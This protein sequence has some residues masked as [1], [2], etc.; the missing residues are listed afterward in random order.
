M[1]RRDNK[2]S[3]KLREEFQS[4]NY[5]FSIIKQ[6]GQG[7]IQN[8]LNVKI[9]T[10]EKQMQSDQLA[11]NYNNYSNP[12]DRQAQEL[13]SHRSDHLGNAIAGAALNSSTLHPLDESTMY[14]TGDNNG[15]EGPRIR[16]Q[17]RNSIAEEVSLEGRQ[18]RLGY[19]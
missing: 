1:I 5:K 14:Y 3:K 19:I 9:P 15:G 13:T 6:R 11:N 2:K 17:S 7:L 18:R 12:F 8:C 16:H 10:I 4:L